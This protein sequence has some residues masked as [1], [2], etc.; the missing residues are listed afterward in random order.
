[1]K[2]CGC[3]IIP[4]HGEALLA[5]SLGG[6]QTGVPGCLQKKL[7]KGGAEE[8]GAA[9]PQSGGAT[10]KRGEHRQLLGA[11]LEAKRGY[12]GAVED[13]RVRNGYERRW[14]LTTRLKT[15]ALDPVFIFG[16]GLHRLKT[17]PKRL[18]RARKVVPAGGNSVK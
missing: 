5:I 12:N 8:C 4:W 11:V 2:N 9:K 14:R 17:E 13:R 6:M 7:Q 10:S 1:V 18:K 15:G 3:V 16:G